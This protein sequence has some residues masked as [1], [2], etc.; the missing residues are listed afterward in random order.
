MP[1][2]L[3][4]AMAGCCG[5]GAPRLDGL[6]SEIVEKPLN[7]SC[8]PRGAAPEMVQVQAVRTAL[9]MYEVC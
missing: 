3:V 9:H 2:N 1:P 8:L 6:F 5:D 4:F 7:S